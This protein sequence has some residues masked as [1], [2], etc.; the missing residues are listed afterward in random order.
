MYIDNSL[1]PFFLKLSGTVYVH[2]VYGNALNAQFS[3]HRHYSDY[4]KT[5]YDAQIHA[6]I[7]NNGIHENIFDEK[8]IKKYYIHN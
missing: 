1:L 3:N 8:M 5:S 7:S 2:N 6:I 4:Q